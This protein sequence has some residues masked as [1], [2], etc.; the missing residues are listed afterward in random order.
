[1]K[2]YVLELGGMYLDESQLVAGINPATYR[3]QNPPARWV[4]IPV[5]AFLLD[6]GGGWL[7]YDTGCNIRE[8]FVPDDA[9]A[10]SP[11]CGTEE[12]LIEARLASLCLKPDDISHVV[13]SHL[14][15]DHAGYLHLFRNAE[16]IVA[17]RE[18]SETVKLY[19]SR[20][21]PD[22]PY[23]YG[24]FDNFLS[25]DGPRWRLL[26]EI[27]T[28]YE[29]VP[30]AAAINFGPGHAYSMTGLYVSLPD[31]G[32]FLLCSDALYRAENFG[33]PVRLPGL[34]Y[35]SI[36]YVNTA[37]FIRKFAAENNAAIIYGH[38]KKQFA[39]LR[40]APEYYS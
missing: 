7:L 10:V 26:Q 39:T 40:K 27:N 34:V 11:F 5:S 29:I 4:Y 17:D 6:Y 16:V 37:E 2:M 15:V 19:Y 32:N 8:A 20:N 3:N 36:G 30:G 38:D 35:D 9:D 22:G 25:P 13:V 14:H 23:K 1:M 18:F 33:P 21:F 31:S 28:K 12:N 24:D